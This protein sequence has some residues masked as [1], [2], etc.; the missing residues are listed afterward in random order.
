ME[1]SAR[2]KR[3]IGAKTLK[4]HEKLSSILKYV[5]VE[6]CQI[7]Q[8][9]YYLLGSFAI[10][11]HRA[12][13]DLDINLDKDEFMKLEKAT[14]K[15]LGN[16]EFYNGQ[17]RWILDLTELYNSITGENVKDFS[18]EAFMKDPRSGYPNNDFSLAKLK[19]KNALDM[20]KNG[21]LFLSLSALLKWKIAMSRPKDKK[22]IKL[23]T[24][25]IP[26]PPGK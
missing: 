26:R 21:H 2:I 13:N 14:G 5:F 11:E 23:I 25:L 20:D 7:D 18:I 17:I 4:K 9:K 16:I 6:I 1:V 19:S 12:I 22:D 8:T 24:R 10:R 15:N 3:T